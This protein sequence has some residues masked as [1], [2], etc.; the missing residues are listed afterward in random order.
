MLQ[1]RFWLI[2]LI[3]SHS[4]LFLDATSVGPNDTDDD[5]KGKVC[6]FAC[7]SKFIQTCHNRTKII[8][9]SY[10]KNHSFIVKS[11]SKYRHSLFLKSRI[12][13]LDLNASPT[14]IKA[15]S[16]N[17]P[18]NLLF[19]DSILEKLNIPVHSGIY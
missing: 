4:I 18:T 14:R 16:H 6:M 1:M 19:I 17:K 15:I 12:Q 11:Y 7:I 5:E 10:K 2:S 3:F 9:L 8:N 13:Y